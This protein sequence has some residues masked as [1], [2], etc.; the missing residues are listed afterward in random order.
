[1]SKKRIIIIVSIVLILVVIG[2]SVY[3]FFFKKPS[4]GVTPEEGG[5]ITQIDSGGGTTAQK[6]SPLKKISDTASVSPVL[7]EDG[8]KVI[9][10]GKSGGIFEVAFNGSRVK[11]T[12]FVPQPNLLQLFWSKQRTTFIALYHVLQEKKFFY[13]DLAEKKIDQLNKNVVMRTIALSPFDNKIAYLST[14]DTRQMYTIVV[15]DMQ[16]GN[17]STVLH[18]RLRDIHL[19]WVNSNEIAVSTIPSGLIPSTLWILNTTSGRLRSVMSDV[20]GLTT[21]WNA[22]GSAFL[23]STSGGSGKILSL[24]LTNKIGTE[25]KK[26]TVQTLPEKCVFMRN[27]KSVICAVPHNTQDMIWPDDYYK[28]IYNTNESIQLIDFETQKQKTLYTFNEKDHINATHLLLSPK[29]DAL[30]F[31]NKSDSILYTLSLQNK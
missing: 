26:G 31:L 17:A 11:E 2:F 8:T 10:A 3:Y 14:D 6:D 27:E 9:Y 25:V 29:E 28:G 15:A 30:I 20:S 5:E 21:K 4:L 22:E 24:S 18:T 16:G 13:N 12:S 7:N 19:T 23:F 1:M